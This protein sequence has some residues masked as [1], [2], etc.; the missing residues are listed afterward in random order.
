MAISYG[1][2][3]ITEVQEGS[4]IWTTTVAP[5]SPNYTFTISNLTGDSETS[6]KVGDIIMYS[7][8]RYTVLSMSADGT[9]VL[10]GNRV[11][12]RGGTGASAVTYSLIVS[13]L[14]IIKDKN[15]DISPTSITLTAKSQTGSSAMANYAGRFKI[16]TTTDNSTWTTQ[17]TSSANES[18]K[19]WDVIDDIIAIRCSL[20]LKDGTT[21]LLDQQTIPVISDGLDGTNGNDAYSIVLTNDNHT[22]AGNTTSAI[23]SQMECNV[24]AY[25]GTTQVTATIGTITGQPTG[26]T[27]AIL[28]NGTTNSAFRVSVTGDMTTRNG[29]L[30]I[31]LTIDGKSFTKEFT[32]SLALKGEPLFKVELDNYY[33]AIP[34]DSDGK[35]ISEC[36]VGIHFVGRKGEDAVATSLV[37]SS[38]GEYPKLFGISP[39]VMNSTIS[40]DSGMHA[41]VVA[42][43]YILYTIPKDTVITNDKGNINFKFNLD[44]ASH[45]LEYN[46]CWS[47]VTQGK[48][49]TSI[50][51]TSTSVTYQ[52]GTSGTVQ[53]TGTWETNI[54]TVAQ[55][56]F[57]WTKTIV[58]YSDG[59][60]T[61]SYSVSRN[62]VNGTNG[63]SPT[64]S[65]TV[66]E[67]A[68]TTS[69]TTTPTS[70]WGTTPPSAT[71]G[72]YMWTKVT[73]T[74]S[75]GATAVSYTVSK[76]GTNGNNGI[77]TAT[78]YLY[79]KGD[80]VPSTPSGNTTYTFSTKKLTGTLDN[81][82]QTIPTT[83]DG[84]CYVTAAVASSSGTTDTIAT[85][86]WST[87]IQFN[88]T[89]GTN[90]DN[91]LNQATI[92]LYKRGTSVTKPTTSVT[93]TFSTGALSAEPNGW[94]RNIPTINGSPCWVVSA[95]AIGSGTTATIAGGNWSAPVKLVEDGKDGGRWYSGT[96]ITGTSTTATVF[97]GSG[98][99][100]A[101]IGDMY[102]NTSTYNTY[103][104]TLGGDA[105]TAKW[106]YVNNIKGVH[107][108]TGKGV[109]S[110]VNQYYLSTSNTTQTGG[111][112]S[113]TVPPYVED[114]YYWTK[115]HI[116]W[117]DN[118]ETDT[119]AVLDNGLTDANANAIDARKVATNY[120]AV[121]NTGIMVANMEDGEQT[122]STATGRN[123]FIDND[124]VDI[125]DGQN[126]LASF[127]GDNTKFYDPIYK[128]ELATFGA[129]GAIIGANS[130]QRF[131]I[132][133]DGIKSINDNGATV[134][135]VNSTEGTV[136]TEAEV[137]PSGETDWLNSTSITID[138]VGSGFSVDVTFYNKSLTAIITI[139]N[140]NSTLT[141]VKVNS[142][143][144]SATLISVGGV[145]FN[146]SKYSVVLPPF[147]F[148]YG[149]AQTISYTITA[150]FVNNYGDSYNLTAV[151]TITYNGATTISLSSFNGECA[152]TSGNNEEESEFLGLW[153]KV[154]YG[155]IYQSSAYTKA[156]AMTFGT[157]GKDAIMAPFS[158]TMGESLYA[159]ND[160][161]LSIGKYN[162]NNDEFFP[163]AFAIGNGVNDTD[164]SNAF[165]VDW[166]GNTEVGGNLEVTG[167]VN[168]NRLIGNSLHCNGA[169]KFTGKMTYNGS[170]G[171][172][173]VKS[174]SYPIATFDAGRAWT[175]QQDVTVSGYLAVAISGFGVYNDGG[176]CVFPK[177]YVWN[178]SDGKDLLDI[179][180]WNQ[181]SSQ[182]KNITVWVKIF[183]I[184]RSAYY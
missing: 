176:W 136:V 16:E 160:N 38:G 108:D 100:S 70:G 85:G 125:R 153:S 177:C 183:Y 58:N 158:V 180:I 147:T 184:A 56:N 95:T 14:A 59:S 7:Y 179:Y 124:S 65:S 118:T 22:F 170:A 143:S 84:E 47:K 161:Q 137:A 129:S 24:I 15:G 110:I 49:G 37:K 164:R 163:L 82:S 33:S 26:M 74:Y 32:Y 13:N 159:N 31:P 169:S 151:E 149:T 55:D 101:V 46:Y 83:G 71:A 72:R 128:K 50:S 146:A 75:D 168:A 97:S 181:W 166:D 103:R 93:Y 90:G 34:V 53:P 139:S 20:Y 114:C 99:S 102:L 3:T 144:S 106:V 135:S 115:S 4:Q 10:A 111:S 105:S 142:V 19:N 91:G 54:P 64:V 152:R 44:G 39:L 30:N 79:K 8:Y 61:E 94:T 140:C 175:S 96:S 36:S 12:I 130:E 25:K 122:P 171:L 89:N 150:S 51:I 67:Y 154:V 2:Y 157:R 5:K 148:T 167:D 141:N 116:V 60:S 98:I 182:L 126:T 28:N 165:N 35:T 43:G 57:L 88:G 121:D 138:T 109:S 41:T 113:T 1:T 86:E 11:S 119:T 123:V 62:A 69:G 42:I 68:Q 127:T 155:E 78:V 76:N 117:T 133:K 66:T 52:E 23:T 63:T 17:Y 112:W 48:D 132:E 45:N 18:T 87:P 172:F 40:Y 156:P 9:T 173:F 81:W 145:G 174:Y 178:N 77:N 92:F 162:L 80:D 27:T 104:C 73:V 134:F 29:T 21:T 131:I 107:G 6:V 120:L